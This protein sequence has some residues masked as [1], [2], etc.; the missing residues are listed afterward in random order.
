MYVE[1]SVSSQNGTYSNKTPDAEEHLMWDFC[2]VIFS[3]YPAMYWQVG[4]HEITVY[5]VYTNVLFLCLDVTFR[6][7]R[8]YLLFI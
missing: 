1:V 7:S 8:Y 6:D 5:R 3:V 2:Y 4:L